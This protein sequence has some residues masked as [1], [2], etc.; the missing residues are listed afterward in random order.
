MQNFEAF[1]TDYL[2]DARAIDFGKEALMR[3]EELLQSRHE[4]IARA[5]HDHGERMRVTLNKKLSHQRRNQA[6]RR[7]PASGHDDTT[8]DATDQAQGSNTNDD[9]DNTN[10][11]HDN[12]N[13][14]TIDYS[15]GTNPF[16]T[17]T[18]RQTTGPLSTQPVNTPRPP[19]PTATSGSSAPRTSQRPDSSVDFIDATIAEII[20]K[21]LLK[22]MEWDDDK[23]HIEE[24]LR[25]DIDHLTRQRKN[26]LAEELKKRLNPAKLL[27]AYDIDD[28]AEILELLQHQRTLHVDD[29]TV[30]ELKLAHK[31]VSY[32]NHANVE[33][34]CKNFLQTLRAW[35]D[36]HGRPRVHEGHPKPA[37]QV[38]ARG[39]WSHTS[40]RAQ[41]DGH[42]RGDPA[43]SP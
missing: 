6:R 5:I 21:L 36:M 31:A 26:A 8:Q 42:H 38:P 30:E 16:P 4:L 9:H 34:Y 35:H 28:P 24:T 12:T 14:T 17:F 1:Q 20:Q 32:M 37:S 18:N 13:D 7:T 25:G 27:T 40:G 23:A 29:E 39:I 33:E 41:L 43:E 15:A 10:D 19:R 3:T 22:T 11:D 2:K